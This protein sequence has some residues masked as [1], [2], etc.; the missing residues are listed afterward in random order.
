[1]G[2]IHLINEMGLRSNTIISSVCFFFRCLCLLPWCHMISLYIVIMT[3]RVASPHPLL[4][5]PLSSKDVP[6]IGPN[7]RCTEIFLKYM[8]YEIYPLQER[9]CLLQGHSDISRGVLHKRGSTV[10]SHCKA[11]I[12]C[13]ILIIFTSRLINQ[14]GFSFNM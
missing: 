11:E 10:C 3:N 6:P 1:M 5:K 4:I 9:P 7:L 12:T 8:Y 13:L 14:I 2:E